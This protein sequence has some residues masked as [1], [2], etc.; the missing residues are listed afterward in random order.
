VIDTETSFT[1]AKD[2]DCLNG[3]GLVQRAAAKHN[4]IVR[5]TVSVSILQQ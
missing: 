3:N 5:G 4:S 2:P 1:F